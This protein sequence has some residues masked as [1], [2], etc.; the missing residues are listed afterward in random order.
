MRSR[1][2]NLVRGTKELLY[3]RRRRE[4]EVGTFTT[5]S[6]TA[7]SAEKAVK[8][9]YPHRSIRAVLQPR[10]LW[11]QGE[12]EEE[13]EEGTTTKKGSVECRCIH[14]HTYI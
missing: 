12:E 8:R 5:G 14:T 11:S 1:R 10:P 2:E 7:L 3:K 9:F 4:D 13:V 6:R